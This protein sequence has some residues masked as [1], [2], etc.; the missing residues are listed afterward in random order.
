MMRAIKSRAGTGGAKGKH[1]RPRLVQ[2]VEE[3][4]EP[5]TYVLTWRVQGDR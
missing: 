2:K 4:V 3:G 5:L 1:V